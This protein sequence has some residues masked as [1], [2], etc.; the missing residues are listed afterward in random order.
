MQ[1]SFSNNL[2][3]ARENIATAIKESGRKRGS[4]NLNTKGKTKGKKKRK[5]RKIK[6][7]VFDDDEY[8]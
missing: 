4:G 5:K 8:D 3:N 6:S 1:E 2:S 7:S